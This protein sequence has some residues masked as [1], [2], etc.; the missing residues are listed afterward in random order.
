MKLI[1]S[2]LVRTPHLH[3]LI[4]YIR[5][6]TGGKVLVFFCFEIC[7][8]FKIKEGKKNI[9]LSDLYLGPCGK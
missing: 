7:S 1:D 2:F 6:S 4:I 8:V 3:L 9:F 5:K